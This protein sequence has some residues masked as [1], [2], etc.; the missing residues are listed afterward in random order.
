MLRLW[1]E[2]IR[3]GLGASYAA[4]ACLAGDKVVHWQM[5]TWAPETD[6]PW[7]KALTTIAEWL[8]E[9]KLRNRRIG[10]ALSSELSPLHLIPWR[11]DVAR[12]DQLALLAGAHFRQVHGDA[13]QHWKVN[14]QPTAYGQPWLAVAMDEHLLQMFSQWTEST[15]VSV[16]PLALSLFNKVRRQLAPASWLLVP[17]PMHTT[18]MHFR[19]GQWRLLKSL[20]D[21]THEPVNERLQREIALSGLE[22]MKT[23]L[24]SPTTMPTATLIDAGWRSGPA[25]SPSVAL[26]LLGGVT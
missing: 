9:L 4:L 15:V 8:A 22:E 6:V 16:Q 2:H 26:Y 7:Q 18:A 23:T 24:Y 12:E 13:A 14:V 19:N 17:E 21:T 5:Q 3:V 25:V 11:E 20:P 10:V 1:P